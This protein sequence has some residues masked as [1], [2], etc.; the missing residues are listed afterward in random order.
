MHEIV[1]HSHT[2]L[3]TASKLLEISMQSLPRLD[4]MLKPESN[5]VGL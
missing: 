5:L 4:Q 1:I 2:R 3:Q